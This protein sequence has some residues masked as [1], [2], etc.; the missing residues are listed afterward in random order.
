M[1]AALQAHARREEQPQIVRRKP[2]LVRSLKP[3]ENYRGCIHCHNVKE[4]QQQEQK[5]QGQWS[6]DKVWRY[7][8]P[9]NIGLTLDV[10][11]G[12][13]VKRVAD[14]SAAGQAG[15]QA[16]DRL[17]SVGSVRVRSFADLQF[18]LDRAP[19]SGAVSVVWFRGSQRRTGLL[20]LIAGWR[21]TDISWRPSM[22]RFLA[23]PRLYGRDLSRDERHMLGLKP[24]QLAFAHRDRVLTQA[25]QAGIRQGDVILGF[26]G[27][28][29]EMTAYEFQT[30]VRKNYIL[31]DRVMINVLRD[32]KRI[33][34]PMTL[35]K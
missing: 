26:D 21:R 24:R 10:D 23:S 8:L 34:L 7:P 17:E 13:I 14:E 30:W 1:L 18:A 3:A 25:R 6:R 12:N 9:E 19:V 31:G 5:R 33:D 4:I 32:R 27:R 35:A 16:G 22:Q 29:L 28:E 11:R 20:K 2:L 15:M